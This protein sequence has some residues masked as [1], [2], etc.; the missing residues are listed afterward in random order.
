MERSGTSG[1]EQRRIHAHR[2][3]RRP[4]VPSAPTGA[5]RT[6]QSERTAPLGA[7]RTAR[8]PRHSC[9]PPRPAREDPPCTRQSPL[10]LATFRSWGIRWMTPH[11]GPGN[12]IPDVTPPRRP[13][14][15]RSHAGLWCR[16]AAAGRARLDRGPPPRG[17]QDRRHGRSPDPTAGGVHPRALDD[18]RDRSHRRQDQAEW[19]R[20]GV[21]GIF[22]FRCTWPLAAWSAW[23]IRLV[24]YG[25]RLESVLGASPRGFESP[26]LRH[27]DRSRRSIAAPV[28]LL[29]PH[30]DPRAPPGSRAGVRACRRTGVTCAWASQ[31]ME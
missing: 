28:L 15:P 4:P 21:V 16:I 3:H 1:A 11:E 12:T 22:A 6:H 26:I 7:R 10:T 27:R 9:R 24:A 14:L 23:R 30:A 2:R 18:A 13:Q 19:R 5:G 31:P 25:A 8:S 20:S 17:P 29:I